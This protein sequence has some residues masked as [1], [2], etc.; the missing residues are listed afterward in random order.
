MSL[1]KSGLTRDIGALDGAKLHALE[2]S[3]ALALGLD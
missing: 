3:L 2:R 1:P